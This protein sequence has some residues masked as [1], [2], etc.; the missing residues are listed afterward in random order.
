MVDA[1]LSR[2]PQADVT[3]YMKRDGDTMAFSVLVTNRS[4]QELGYHNAATVHALLYEE[5]GDR[6]KTRRFVIAAPYAALGGDTALPD[7]A[8]GT[9]SMTIGSLVDVDW[10]NIHGV[11]LVDYRP[12]GSSG[13]YNALQ[14]AVA[15]PLGIAPE[16]MSFWV[17]PLATTV[18][19]QQIDLDA[20]DHLTWTLTRSADWVTLGATS[21]SMT[22][23]PEL[24]V[25]PAQLAAGRQDTAVTL[26]FLDAGRIVW[27]QEI[28]VTAYYG[29]LHQVRIPLAMKVQ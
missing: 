28:P 8:T 15:Y 22:Q 1:A 14:A 10:H 18:E 25:D 24:S 16:T 6:G 11:A 21:G 20:P 3:A 7:G 26:S 5:G 17:E 23:M 9:F 2:P 29:T 27:T 19:P 13:P 4:G 12:A